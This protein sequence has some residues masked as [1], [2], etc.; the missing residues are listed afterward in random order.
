MVGIIILN[1]NGWK[2]TISC[3]ESLQKCKENFYTLVYDNGSDDQSIDKIADF[4]NEGAIN[5]VIAD[6]G[7]CIAQPNNK[8]YYL[9]KGKEN[10]GFAK[11]NNNAIK[12]LA[13]NLPEYILLL[14]NDTIVE[15]DFLDKLTYFADKNIGYDAMTPV[16]CYN[17]NR[18]VVW[19]CG[20]R[21][22]FGLRKY[23]YAKK[24]ISDIK[25]MSHINISFVTG[26]ALLFRPDVLKKD[27]CLF[28]EN[29]FFGEEDF[30]FCI[31]MNKERRKMACVLDSKIYHKVSA[32]TSMKNQNGKIFIHYLNR[33]I[34][35]R[36]NY[37]KLFYLFW[38]MLNVA[39][40][41]PLLKRN[42]LG[43]KSTI[44]FL[45]KLL[46]LSMVKNNVT[47][48]DFTEAINHWA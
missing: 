34:D 5:Y 43:I 8:Y 30:N 29:F 23:Y 48:Q 35:V 36:Q 12:L 24:N 2:D 4:L 18:D 10:Y 11:G 45:H 38:L 44:V 40:L 21:Q 46:K 19:N 26:C 31:R 33:F 22:L 28:T 25:E 14:N 17:S 37:S 13:K 15:P 7:K 41:I 1:W 6:D 42:G 9:V 20:G 32:S 47:R 39:Y 27:G 3:I 16:I